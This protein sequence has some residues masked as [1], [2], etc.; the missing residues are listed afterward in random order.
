MFC[1]NIFCDV[2]TIAPFYFNITFA[3]HYKGSVIDGRDRTGWFVWMIESLFTN[4]AWRSERSWL[5]LG[6]LRALRAFYAYRNLAKVINKKT[7]AGYETALAMVE[8]ILELFCLVVMWVGVVMILEIMGE[9]AW[10]AEDLIPVRGNYFGII[11][12]SGMIQICIKYYNLFNSV[13]IGR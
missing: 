4:L 9:P 1:F 2:F 7:L 8:V 11:V 13:L 3:E 5:S 12:A 10:I 6:F